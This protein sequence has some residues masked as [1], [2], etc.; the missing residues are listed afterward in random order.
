MNS[1]EFINSEI[2]FLEDM[3]NMDLALVE[4]EFDLQE[5]SKKQEKLQTLQQ[6]KTELEAWE[7]V[8]KDIILDTDSYDC[9]DMSC[10][11]EYAKFY[12]DDYEKLDKLYKAL[13]VKDEDRE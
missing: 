10:T 4:D 13:E 9:D 7:V 2:K 5:I 6:I 8:K 1:L 3:I 12:T 11:F